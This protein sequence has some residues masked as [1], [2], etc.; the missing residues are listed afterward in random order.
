LGRGRERGLSGGKER[1]KEGKGEKGKE[2]GMDGGRM[3]IRTPLSKSLDPP[4]IICTGPPPLRE[5]CAKN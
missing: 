1:G 2:E 3:I 5:L 4:L